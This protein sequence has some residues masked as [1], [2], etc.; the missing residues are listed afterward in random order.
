MQ[1]G[2]HSLEGLGYVERLD[3]S[4]KPWQLPFDD[5][6]WGRFLSPTDV[7]IWIKWS[8]STE[9][10]TI[11]HNGIEQEGA[12]LGDQSVHLPSG[13]VL[14]FG[15]EQ[16]LR[17]GQLGSTALALIPFARAFVP[18]FGAAHETKWLASGI[19]QGGHEAQT[20]WVVYEAVRW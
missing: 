20:G 16:I 7:V 18:R 8:G 10:T 9:R 4:I 3:V 2:N 17:S 12:T 1:V 5:L 14:E 13:A 19:V 11:F 6:R 15:E